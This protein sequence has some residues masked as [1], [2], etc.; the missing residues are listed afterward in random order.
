V[1]SP[2][3]TAPASSPT[4]SAT[5]APS[6]TTAPG[7]VQPTAGPATPTATGT[8]PPTATST[9]TPSPTATSTPT[10]TA[11]PT[12]TATPTLAPP[13]APSN[14]TAN[15]TGTGTTLSWNDNSNNETGFKIYWRATNLNN[16][17]IYV[18]ND[19]TV[20]ANT[21]STSVEQ[22]VLIATMTDFRRGVSA[23]NAAGE[24]VIV[25]DR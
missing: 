5:A 12:P 17:Q 1:P 2:S 16:G 6:A 24:S 18:E 11:T 19:K 9:N 8:P 15:V 4:A 7:G 3:G 25:W 10:N 23:Y 21:T 22:I 13:N 20:P 14:V